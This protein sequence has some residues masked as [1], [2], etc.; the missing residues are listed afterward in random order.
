[1]RN[2]MIKDKIAPKL[3]LIYGGIY[4]K[5]PLQYD[6][7]IEVGIYLPVSAPNTPIKA[8]AAALFLTYADIKF[9][10]FWSQIWTE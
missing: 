4:N 9:L 5:A 8:S 2:G 6:N 10:S 1:M 7:K 3:C